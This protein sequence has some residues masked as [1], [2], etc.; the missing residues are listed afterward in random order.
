[1]SLQCSVN[2]CNLPYT[3]L[4]ISYID[5][6]HKKITSKSLSPVRAGAFSLAQEKPFTFMTFFRYLVH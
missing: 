2:S 5:W 6:I 4:S 3:H 1:S